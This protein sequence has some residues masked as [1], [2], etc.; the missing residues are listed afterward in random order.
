MLIGKKIRVLEVVR[1]TARHGLVRSSFNQVF[2]LGGIAYTGK[3][4]Q[5]TRFGDDKARNRRLFSY[6]VNGATTDREIWPSRR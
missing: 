2:Y 4:G 5:I 3:K 1:R 6:A